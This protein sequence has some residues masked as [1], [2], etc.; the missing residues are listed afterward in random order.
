MIDR[1]A[2]VFPVDHPD[3]PQCAGMATA[4]HDPATC[5]KRGKHNVVRYSVHATNDP[6]V[7]EDLEGYNYGIFTPKSNLIVLDEDTVGALARLAEKLGV[8]L[9]ETFTVRTH[10]GRRHY[11]FARGDLEIGNGKLVDGIDVRAGSN[12]YVV[13]PGSLHGT[14]STYEVEDWDAPFAD[15]P[16]PLADLLN[17]KRSTHGDFEVVEPEPL[18]GVNLDAVLKA[19][20]DKKDV[21][22]GRQ[23]LGKDDGLSEAFYYIVATCK[24]NGLTQGQALSAMLP[25]CAKY[26]KYVGREAEQVAIVWAKLPAFRSED[27]DKPRIGGP[28]GKGRA[29]PASQRRKVLT[30]YAWK[31]RIPL[32]SLTIIA[33]QGDTGK[34]TICCE[35]AARVS[36]GELEGNLHGIPR[37]VLYIVVEADWDTEI[38]PRFVAADGDLDRIY[39]FEIASTDQLTGEEVLSAVNFPD[40]IPSLKETI[41][42]L[43]PAMIIL[44]PLPSRINS[45]LNKY[46]ESEVRQGLEPLVACAQKYGLALVGIMHFNKNEG[47]SAANR[48]NGSAAFRDLPRSVMVAVDDPENDIRY[49]AHEKH[50]LGLKQPTLKYKLDVA[51]WMEETEEDGLQ[52][53]SASKVV[54]EGTDTRRIDTILNDIAGSRHSSGGRRPAQ[55]DAVRIACIQELWAGPMERGKLMLRIAEQTHANPRTIERV[56][57]DKSTF[58]SDSTGDFPKTVTY[59]LTAKYAMNDDA[60]ADEDN[61]LFRLLDDSED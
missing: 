10:D 36:R 23:T 61:D 5:D 57:A 2:F 17:E 52:E 49:L 15:L 24:E 8:S 11:Y 31:D 22:A 59:R 7:V 3:R 34:S 14:G 53:T 32:R 48:M 54:W 38:A 58:I 33:G 4:S 40:D 37:N 60:A 56:L 1:G 51:K 47:Q 45:A 46:S 21:T 28:R 30:K 55:S 39:R 13:G 27:F 20:A 12:G 29:T 25:W 26:G 9:P 6:R 16:K 19:M 43:D 41:E 35:L 44:D 42:E 18:K 50:N